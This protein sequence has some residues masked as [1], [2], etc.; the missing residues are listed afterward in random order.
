MRSVAFVRLSAS[1]GRR[2]GFRTL[3]S[4]QRIWRP[5][6]A[7]FSVFEDKKFAS[8]PNNIQPPVGYAHGGR[9]RQ[10]STAKP[11]DSTPTPTSRQ[12][13]QLFLFSAIP[14]VG[15][16]FADNFIMIVAGDAIDNTLGIR[17][18]I[19]TLA[20]AGLGNLISD[21][22]GIGLGEVVEN[23]SRKLGLND[24]RLTR[25][26]LEMR[27]TRWVKS[28]ACILGISLGCILGMV[29]LLFLD[30]HKLFFF[31]GEE[32]KLYED[33]FLKNNVPPMA[34][35]SLIRKA[36]WRKAEKGDVIVE[37]GLKF[38]KVLIL[39][40][41]VAVGYRNGKSV[42]SYRGQNCEGKEPVGKA[43]GVP[44]RGCVI[45]GTALVDPSVVNLPYKN[46]VIAEEDVEYLEFTLSDLKSSMREDKHIRAAMFSILYK[47]LVVGLRSRKLQNK[48]NLDA[49][50]KKEY[51]NVLEAVLA[52]GLVRDIPVPWRTFVTFV[53]QIMQLGSSS[54]T[55]DRQ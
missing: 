1:W 33:L 51:M 27:K 45:G 29:P 44:K 47:D 24:P 11:P 36:K 40:T 49:K 26:Q 8:D 14:F 55:K 32:E 48:V 43:K 54:G 53:T 31:S 41:G 52:D 39:R 12:L 2:R 15:F 25:E 20:A 6:D 18:G 22:C 7:L 37:S 23:W 13:W 46:H 30:D 17:M 9:R 38:E 4:M 21:V 16:G 3:E 42:F 19:S 28:L 50:R 10:F 5:K 35:F 34:F